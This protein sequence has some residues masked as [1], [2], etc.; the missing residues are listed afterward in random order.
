MHRK[1]IDSRQ[2][3][4]QRLFELRRDYDRAH[5]RWEILTKKENLGPLEKQRKLALEKEMQDLKGQVD[6]ER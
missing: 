6:F 2:F 1:N 4:N 5:R 3:P